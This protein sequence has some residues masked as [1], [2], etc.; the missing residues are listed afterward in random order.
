MKHLLYVFV[1]VRFELDFVL[2]QKKRFPDNVTK[3][4][5]NIR[6]NS[7]LIAPSSIISHKLYMY[8]HKLFT[9]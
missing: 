9:T 5:F 3:Y 7:L 6:I 1:I 8:I 4:K 2:T